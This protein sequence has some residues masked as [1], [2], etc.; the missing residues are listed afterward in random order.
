MTTITLFVY[1]TLRNSRTHLLESCE[2]LGAAT[3]GGILYDIDGK[4]P[5]LLMY[6]DAPV[7]GEVWRCPWDILEYIDRYEGVSEGMFR[8]VAADVSL[9][10]DEL[11]PCWLY[12][13][14]PA[15]SHRLTPE[16]RVQS[17]EWSD[18]GLPAGSP[19]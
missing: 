8:R 1:G 10:N 7:T 5:A 11:V 17:G 19:P 15:I 4:F 9:S 16:R 14:G 13:A 3:I 12:T 2:R 6:G 18:G